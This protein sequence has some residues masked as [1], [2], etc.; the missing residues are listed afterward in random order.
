[1]FGK[2][3]HNL[4]GVATLQVPGNVPLA[5][6]SC[7]YHDSLGSATP[8]ALRGTFDI[9]LE[10]YYQ[11]D[12]DFEKSV[13]LW[14]RFPEKEVV[15][16]SQDLKRAKQ[17]LPGVPIADLAAIKTKCNRPCRC[18]RENNAL[19]L[20]QFC[21]MESLHGTEFLTKV[22]SE[23]RRDKRISIMDSTHRSPLL[24]DSVHYVDDTKPIPCLA[25]GEEVHL[26][27][28]TRGLAHY[29]LV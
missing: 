1:M 7:P 25:C 13:E 17:L 15:M 2:G 6:S 19:D 21:I 27:L 20:I 22:L 28:L 11:S 26:Y 3:N 8:Q 29:W 24:A 10:A 4:L 18:G 9:D 23:K 16:Q 14:N 5:Q 12:A